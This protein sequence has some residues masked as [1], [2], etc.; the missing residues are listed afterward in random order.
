MVRPVRASESVR[1]V[2]RGKRMGSGVGVGG[3]RVM[4]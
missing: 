4:G 2:G 1:D 3:K